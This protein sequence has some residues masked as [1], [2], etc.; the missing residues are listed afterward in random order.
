M[1]TIDTQ[2]I[3]LGQ[4]IRTG[5]LTKEALINEINFRGAAPISLVT[6][7]E[8][9]GDYNKK[10][11]PFWDKKEKRWHILK[12]A[13]TNGFINVNYEKAVNRQRARE[14][15]SQG[16]ES[17][18]RQWGDRSGRVRGTSLIEHTRKDGVHKYYLE[19]VV[20]KKLTTEFIRTDTGD[21]LTAPELA[22][23]KPFAKAKPSTRQGVANEI[24]PRDFDLD[25]II[26]ITINGK[27]F[28]FVR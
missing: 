5:V 7:T 4:A 14:S 10:G 18:P 12:Y 20:R 21:R 28:R 17:Q 8:P 1:K 11:N 9:N 24:K 15:R 16:F 13:V 27:G 2:Q 6:L 3:T 22:L 25:N 26:G 19:V 23:L